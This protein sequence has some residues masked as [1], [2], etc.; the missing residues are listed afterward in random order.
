MPQAI[1]R[2]SGLVTSGTTTVYTCPSSTIAIVLPSI[3]CGNTGSSNTDVTI[4]WNSSTTASNGTGNLMFQDFEYSRGYL[5][6]YTSKYD[7]QIPVRGSTAARTWYSPHF[8]SNV[9][10]PYFAFG[11]LTDSGHLDDNNSAYGEYVPNQGNQASGQ[12][13]YYYLRSFR[14]GAWHMGAGHKLSIN[15]SNS[16]V[17]YCFLIIEE[18]V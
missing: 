16:Y 4:G 13:A 9:D 5:V 2:F 3:N 11:A 12:D 15:V 1:K 8:T 14:T 7:V 6:S 17:H 18:A 10:Q